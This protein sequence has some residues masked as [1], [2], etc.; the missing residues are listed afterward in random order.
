MREGS[1]VQVGAAE[2]GRGGTGGAHWSWLQGNPWKSPSQEAAV[3]EDQAR[4]GGEEMQ[5]FV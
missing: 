2:A 4:R 5:N 1:S 3:P